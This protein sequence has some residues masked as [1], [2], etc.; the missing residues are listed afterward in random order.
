MSSTKFWQNH[1]ITITPGWTISNWTKVYSCKRE[2]IFALQW[3]QCWDFPQ[4]FGWWLWYTRDQHLQSCS[5]DA[6]SVIMI[7]FILLYYIWCLIPWA[8]SKCHLSAPQR[9][10]ENLHIW[11]IF[12]KEL[13][14]LCPDFEFLF[15]LGISRP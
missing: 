15:L 8:V 14:Y 12:L 4:K 3:W 1:S 10:N 13:L 9:Q 11:G 6:F 7:L 5:Q 2:M